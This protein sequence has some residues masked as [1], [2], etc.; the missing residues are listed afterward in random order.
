MNEEKYI[1]FGQYLQGEMSAEEKIDFEK[2]LSENHELASEFESFKEVQIQLETKFDFA[3]DR[4]AFEANL[5]T[6]SKEHFKPQKTKVI[7]IKTWTYLVAASVV[8]LL[9]LFLFNPSKPGFE[10]YNQYENAYLTERGDGIENLK[11]AESAFNAK[12]YKAAIPLFE[13]VLKENKSAEIQY[14]YGISLLENNQIKEAEMAFNE[15]KL[16][17][18]IYKNKAIY[19]LALAKLK[20]KDY[21]GCKEILLTIPSDY[22]NYDKV[23]ELLDKLD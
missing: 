11:Q 17:N 14:F 5:K 18:S 10:E 4:D 9:G 1:L 12:N 13:T 19:G 15:I 6:I 16:G 7:S 2:K 23:Q 8:L 3:A 21:K 22:E 20:Q